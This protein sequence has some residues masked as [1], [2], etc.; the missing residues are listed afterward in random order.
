MTTVTALRLIQGTALT[1]SNVTL[2]TSA[3]G[4]KTVIQASS[5]LN[6]SANAT[7][8]YLYLVASGGTAAAASAAI[9]ASLAAGATYPCSEI[10]NQVLEPGDFISARASGGTSLY[11]TAS[12][13]TIA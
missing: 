3:T 1:T 5:V 6:E 8:M 7:V 10:I 13:V 11:I 2:Y 4:T 9:A 12:G